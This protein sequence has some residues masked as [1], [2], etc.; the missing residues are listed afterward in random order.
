M[1]WITDVVSEE[2]T[3]PDGLCGTR[4]R[5]TDRAAARIMRRDWVRRAIVSASRF[6]VS[7]LLCRKRDVRRKVQKA[8]IR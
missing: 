4:S 2:V 8:P 1:F 6:V 3:V 5:G 7:G